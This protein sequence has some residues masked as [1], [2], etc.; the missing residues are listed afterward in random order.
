MQ[1]SIYFFWSP[2]SLLYCI[3]FDSPTPLP[4]PGC[5]HTC[6]EPILQVSL[7]HQGL[8]SI[9]DINSYYC[10]SPQCSATLLHASY[11]PLLFLPLSHHPHFVLM[12]T[13]LP[14]SP[15][16]N[17][18]L[19]CLFCVWYKLL[20]YQVMYLRSSYPL[21]HAALEKYGR[22]LPHSSVSLFQPHLNITCFFRQG[23]SSQ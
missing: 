8:P 16:E 13:S 3:L 15:Q 4:P 20:F 14:T 22:V 11:P 12:I 7:E 6:L 23:Y 9:N 1:L 5:S 10:V 21:P 17:S 18:F 2:L 19:T